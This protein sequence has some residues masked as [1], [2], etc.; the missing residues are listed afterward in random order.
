MPSQMATQNL[1][2]FISSS[3]FP[4]RP[5]GVSHFLDAQFPFAVVSHCLLLVTQYY[6]KFYFDF[7]YERATKVDEHKGVH[8]RKVIWIGLGL[9]SSLAY[10]LFPG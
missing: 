4:S 9:L 3:I 8:K 7:S 2:D 10:L 1:T 5:N 6:A